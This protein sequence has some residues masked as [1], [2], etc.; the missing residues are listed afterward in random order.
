MGGYKISKPEDEG[1]AILEFVLKL[2][3]DSNLLSEF[4]T[5]P[6]KSMLEAGI[7]SEE[8]RTIIKSGNFIKLGRLLISI[9][10]RG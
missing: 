9:N 5:D 4:N 1:P 7:S 2:H 6:D 8:N 10:K 3:E